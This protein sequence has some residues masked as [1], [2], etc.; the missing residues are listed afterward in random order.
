MS[1]YSDAGSEYYDSD[2]ASVVDGTN[3]SDFDDEPILQVKG[4]DKRREVEYKSLS[5]AQ[6]QDLIDNDISQVAS[7]VG[8]E[9]P[10]VS[11]LLRHFNWNNDRLIEKFLDSAQVVLRDA[12]EPELASG[13]ADMRPPPAKRIRLDSP[14]APAEFVCG[15]CCD[16]NPPAMFRLRCQHVFCEPCW[17]E[18]VASKVKDEGQCTFRCMHGDCRTIVDG[19]S[20]AKLVPPSVNERYRELVRQHYVG[21]HTHLRFCPHPGCTETVSCQAGTGSSLLWGVPTVKCGQGHVFCFG[22]GMDSDHRPVICTFTKLWLKNARDDAGTSQWIRANTRTCPKCE[23][24]IEK[25]GGCNRIH[26][27][28]CNFQFCWLCMKDWS[29]HGYNNE[30]CNAWK[31]PEPKESETQAK[32][33]LQK[34]LFY[35]DRFNNHEISAQLDEELCSRTEEKMVEWQETSKMS[36]IEVGFSVPY[37]QH[38]TDVCVPQSTFMRDAVDELTRCRRTL[39][40][41]YTMAYFLKA[42]NQKQIFEDIQADLEKAVEDLSQLLEEPVESGSVKSLRQRMVDKTVY[43][44]ARHETLLRDTADGLAEGRWEWSE[45]VN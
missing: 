20:I 21:A 24:N 22:C 11:I 29:A 6:L 19:C 25:N 32:Q 8:L 2:D 27:R 43:V 38:K 28:H 23:N 9:S 15:V 40:W 5:M 33:N 16:D 37:M 41:S 7:I 12:G 31:E 14:S 36:W 42:G 35:F 44:R 13:T 10:M 18:Y 45:P 26:C 34:W 1:D 30:L 39:K 3:D 17:Q 4:K